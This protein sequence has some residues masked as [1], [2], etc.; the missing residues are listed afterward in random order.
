[1]KYEVGGCITRNTGRRLVKQA[2]RIVSSGGR[3][4]TA[5]VPARQGAI[6]IGNAFFQ[7]LPDGLALPLVRLAM[8]LLT[9]H[10][11]IPNALA[12][13]ALLEVLVGNARLAA[14]G[15]ELFR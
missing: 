14:R 8:G 10:I 11:A 1:M 13:V 4:A 6:G 9:G 7:N 15:A 5:G 2:T 3:N 12:P